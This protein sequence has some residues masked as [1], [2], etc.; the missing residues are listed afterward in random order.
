MDKKKSTLTISSVFHKFCYNVIQK[1][2]N[3]FKDF[4]KGQTKIASFKSLKVKFS[5]NSDIKV[6]LLSDH[7]YI[8]FYAFFFVIYKIKYQNNVVGEV[9]FILFRV[10]Y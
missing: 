10:E 7:V 1:L 6:T 5:Q 2:A 9:L 4:L 8:F 3:K